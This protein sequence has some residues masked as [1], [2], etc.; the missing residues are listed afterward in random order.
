MEGKFILKRRDT[1]EWRGTRARVMHLWL[2]ENRETTM[3]PSDDSVVYPSL[4]NLVDS[5]PQHQL[6]HILNRVSTG[7]TQTQL[8]TST[9]QDDS[10]TIPG[11]RGGGSRQLWRQRPTT[12]WSKPGSTYLSNRY[13]SQRGLFHLA[14]SRSLQSC[15]AH[16]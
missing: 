15:H 4:R 14:Q 2:K 10:L 13:P 9:S 6:C 7:T 12:R 1:P 8:R 3:D 5:T 16:P 11:H